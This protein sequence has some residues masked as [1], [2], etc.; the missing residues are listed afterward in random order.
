[1][2]ILEYFK[3]ELESSGL[4]DSMVEEVMPR[5]IASEAM[6]N[7]RSRWNDQTTDYPE[8]L[9]RVTWL[10]ICGEVLKYIDEKCPQAWFRPLFDLQDPIHKMTK[11]ELIAGTPK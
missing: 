2:T 6:S 7:M 1:M 3:K 5:I 10:L 9:L 8:G 4:F 11:E